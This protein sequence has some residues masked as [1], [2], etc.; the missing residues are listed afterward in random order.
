M[1]IGDRNGAISGWKNPYITDGLIAMWDGEWNA[2]GG[3]HD[4]NATTW[5]DLIGDCDCAVVNGPASWG[6]KYFQGNRSTFFKGVSTAIP[7][8]ISAVQFHLDICL[9]FK[10]VPTSVSANIE[11]GQFGVMGDGSGY[12]LLVPLWSWSANLYSTVRNSESRVANAGLRE[13]AYTFSAD[14]SG[15]QEIFGTRYSLGIGS[16][17]LSSA[18]I[19]LGAFG[20][21]LA[22]TYCTYSKIYNI[23]LYNR[24]LTDTEKAAN[25]EIDK[26]RFMST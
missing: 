4:Q 9:D 2:G 14:S 25:D 1:L 6:D 10:A 8:A 20:E 3:K 23:R 18:T 13:G 15:Y 17:S 11:Q 12:R 5:K 26:S 7:Q 19:T 16:L 21:L 24:S 22:P